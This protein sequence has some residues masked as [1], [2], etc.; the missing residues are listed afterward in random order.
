MIKGLHCIEMC[1][2]MGSLSLSCRVSERLTIKIFNSLFTT[3]APLT[4]KKIKCL[5]DR[6][7][8]PPRHRFFSRKSSWKKCANLSTFCSFSVSWSH[9][10]SHW[11]G[12][13]IK[14]FQ[15]CLNCSKAFSLF[16][17]TSYVFFSVSKK[18]HTLRAEFLL[19]LSEDLFTSR[20]TAIRCERGN[21]S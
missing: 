17:H 14:M 10:P 2:L 6:S 12:Y 9:P 18:F 21:T 13:Y 16:T 8:I 15:F 5:L 19:T 7:E 20:I 3:A 4:S 1:R 11:D